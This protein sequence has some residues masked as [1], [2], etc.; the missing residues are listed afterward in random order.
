[1]FPQLIKLSDGFHSLDMSNRGLEFDK[2][3]KSIMSVYS[4]VTIPEERDSPYDMKSEDETGTEYF[5]VK[6]ITDK[7][8]QRPTEY[9]YLSHNEYLFAKEQENFFYVVYREIG[10][11]EEAHLTCVFSFEFAKEVGAMELFD[12]GKKVFCKATGK[13]E[14]PWSINITRVQQFLS[15]KEK[16]EELPWPWYNSNTLLMMQQ[17]NGEKMGQPAPTFVTQQDQPAITPEKSTISWVDDIA[18]MH[19]KF[20]VNPVI[21]TLDKD[22]LRT[23]LQFRIDFLK[24]ELTEMDDALNDPEFKKDRADE[25]VDALIDLCVVAIGTLNAF[26]IDADK[27]WRRVHEK[28][29]EK[30][31]GVNAN[32]PNPLGLPDLI[33][34]EGWTAPSHM[35]NV[36]ILK[37]VFE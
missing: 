21:R 23:F 29:M 1:M 33:K 22:K 20:G 18:D 8:E 32:R 10:L 27:A 34:P 4:D 16:A 17:P 25:T 6:L 28:N 19:T 35:D 24:E 2:L 26:D 31:P 5:D 9:V 7:N 11:F 14:T 15:N 12:A 3:F 37:K 36:G 13:H 30:N